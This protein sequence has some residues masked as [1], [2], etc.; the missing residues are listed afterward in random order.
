MKWRALDGGK[1][2]NTSLNDQTRFLLSLDGVVAG[3]DYQLGASL[4]DVTLVGIAIPDFWVLSVPIL[5]GGLGMGIQLA[6][7]LVDGD[8]I[9]RGHGGQGDQ[10]RDAAMGIRADPGEQVRQAGLQL[11]LVGGGSAPSPRNRSRCGYG[12]P[13]VTDPTP[14]KILGAG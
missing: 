1:R 6:V 13:D 5:L 11:G 4:N 8:G 12:N 2:S 7:D 10:D 3:W 14:G 9:A